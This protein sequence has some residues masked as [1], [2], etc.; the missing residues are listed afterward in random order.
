VNKAEFK[1][2]IT[3]KGYSSWSAYADHMC[4]PRKRFLAHLKTGNFTQF[5]IA[6]F[7]RDLK[8]SV[9]RMFEIFFAEMV[10]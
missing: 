10:S 9:E 3:R 1:V 8:L 7:V 4:I 6:Q 2:E 5:E